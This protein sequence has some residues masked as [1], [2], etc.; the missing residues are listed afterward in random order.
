MTRPLTVAD[1]KARV[2]V[3]FPGQVPGTVMHGR[4]VSIGGRKRRADRAVIVLPSG[5]H[6]NRP[7]DQLTLVED[8]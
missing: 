8:T 1:A 3:A 2:P 4:L 5:R 7:L 6:V